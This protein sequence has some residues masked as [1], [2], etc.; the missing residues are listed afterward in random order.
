MNTESS[1]NDDICAELW[2]G[3]FRKETKTK[4]EKPNMQIVVCQNAKESAHCL[5]LFTPDKKKNDEQIAN[6][7]L[8]LR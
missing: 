6:L 4:N 7:C 8:L 1:F 3:L 2:N 5:S